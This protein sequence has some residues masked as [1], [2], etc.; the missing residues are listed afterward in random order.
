M[1]RT[2]ASRGEGVAEVVDAIDGHRT[3]LERTGELAER[4]RARAESEIEAIAFANLRSRIGNLHG[5][6]RLSSLASRVAAGDLDPYAAADSL[7]AGLKL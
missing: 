6:A 5:D 2:V 7:V 4:R 3:W 1:L